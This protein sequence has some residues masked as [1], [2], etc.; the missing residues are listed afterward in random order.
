MADIKTG[1]E[2]AELKGLLKRATEE[3]PVRCAIGQ[4]K[5]GAFALLLAD[6]TKQPRALATELEKT[7][8]GMK[9][10]RWGTAYPD[11]NRTPLDP[12]APPPATPADPPD[13]KLVIF[14]VNKPAQGLAKRLAKTLKL[15]MTGFSRVEL[16]FEDGSA[17]EK[18]A[19]EEDEAPAASAAPPPPAPPPPPS[20]PAP[21]APDA[22][23]ALKKKLGELIPKIAAASATDEALKARLMKL[24]GDANASLKANA[25]EDADKHISALQAALDGGAKPAPAAAAAGPVA[26]AKS[27]LAWIAARKKMES[28]VEKLRTEILAYYKDAGMDGE[29]ADAY[30][31]RV[32]PMMEALDEELADKLDEATNAT[33]PAQRAKLVTEAKAAIARYQSFLAQDEGVASLDSNPFVPLTIQQTITTT[34][35]ALS[36]AVH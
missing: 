21:P 23:A 28:E 2:K 30:S 10:P 6:K 29:L 16:R 19:E 31:K 17:P 27:R 33:D 36:A 3:H 14:M 12:N 25:V 13:E 18:V 7:F 9:N 5:E 20:P 11:A 15:N 4:P 1:T 35:A 22:A 26:Y 34:L 24:A 32:G 8:D